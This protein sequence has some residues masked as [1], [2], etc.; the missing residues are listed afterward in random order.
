MKDHPKIDWKAFKTAKYIHGTKFGRIYLIPEFDAA[1]TA[2]IFGY[3]TCKDYYD[4]ASSTHN[5]PK[6]KTPLL[7]LH[8]LDDP[9]ACISLGFYAH[10][11][12]KCRYLG[13]R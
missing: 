9:I 12:L 8:A 2:P 13:M 11:K 4:T 10:V 6:I 1:V 3:A 7:I 5:L